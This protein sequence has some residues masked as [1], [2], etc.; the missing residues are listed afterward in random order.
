M[1]ATMAKLGTPA[2]GAS[3]DQMLANMQK[4]MPDPNAMLAQQ[5]ARM[6]AMKAKRPAAPAAGTAPPAPAAPGTIAG[7]NPTNPFLGSDE[8]MEESIQ[9]ESSGFRNDELSRIMTLIHHR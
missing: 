3:A 4:A 5:Q 9:R 2:P 6:A 8:D 1:K 7:V